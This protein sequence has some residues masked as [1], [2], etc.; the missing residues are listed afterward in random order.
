MHDQA[1][2]DCVEALNRVIDDITVYG[3]LAASDSDALQELADHVLPVLLRDTAVDEP[4]NLEYPDVENWL[5]GLPIDLRSDA[6]RDAIADAILS[7]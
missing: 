7:L 6:V 2:K 1:K 3:I 5:N 4:S